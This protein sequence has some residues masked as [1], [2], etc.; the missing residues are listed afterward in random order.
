MVHP[1]LADRRV[2]N[3]GT[4]WCTRLPGCALAMLALAGGGPA[5]TRSS[6]GP[7]GA[8][9]P[10]SQIKAA[11]GGQSSVV[12]IIGVVTYAFANGGRVIVEDATAGILVDLAETAAP[13]RTGTVLRIEGHVV[14]ARE[15]VIAATS[16]REHEA[17]PVPR[18]TSR[19]I[20]DVAATQHR[21]RQTTLEGV[22]R[23]WRS[24]QDGHT[25][26]VIA[27]GR[28]Q[29]TARVSQHAREGADRYVDA[30][31][32]VTGAGRAVRDVRGARIGIDLLVPSLDQIE[33]IEPAPEAFTQPL[34]E[35][36]ALGHAPGD[37]PQRRVHVRGRLTR[38]RD[39]TWR[40][41]DHTG[42]VA[43][44]RVLLDVSAHDTLVSVLGV[45]RD[46]P[47]QRAR[48]ALSEV[49]IGPVATS[50]HPA[51]TVEPPARHTPITAAAELRALPRAVAGQRLPVSLRG[52]VTYFDP[53]WLPLFVQD[54]SGG[55]YVHL[56]NTSNSEH[57]EPGDVVEVTGRSDS[58]GFAPMVAEPVIRRT[59]R[60]ALP[61]P[62]TVPVAA[63][64]GGRYDSAWVETEAII[65]AAERAESDAHLTLHAIDGANRFR[66]TMPATADTPVPTHLVDARVR[67][68]GV[69]GAVYNGRQQMLGVQLLVPNLSLI[70]VLS[71]P[72][73]A[74][75]S[76]PVQ[77]VSAP[78]Q[79]SPDDEA[80]HRL[81]V[82]G[83]VTYVGAGRML[84]VQDAVTGLLVETT[85]QPPD[86]QPGDHV[87]VAGFP[88]TGGATASLQHAVVRRLAT[89][90]PPDPELVTADEVMTGNHDGR[91]V[92][93]DA[94]LL[95]TLPR[96]AQE[97]LLTLQ[98]GDHVF[99]AV[100]PVSRT[101]GPAD[102]M[103]R[104]G[105]LVS[106]T[107]VCA[108]QAD[109]TTPG[110]GGSARVESFRLL[111]RSPADVAVLV[112]APWWNMTHVITLAGVLGLV[113]LSGIGWVVSL[114]RTVLVQ[115][116]LIQRQLD[117]EARLTLEAQNANRAKSEFLANMSH[118]IRT[119]MNAVIGMTGLLLDTPLSAEQR[120]FVSTV[121]S[122]GD[123]LLHLI[124][125]ILDFS[126]I[127]S[128]HL[129]VESRPFVLRH[130]V[131]DT[132]DL[133]AAQ[134]TDKGLD[135]AAVIDADCPN[136]LVGDA[137]RLRQ[138]LVNLVGNAVKF[139][140]H[141]AVVLRVSSTRMSDADEAPYAWTFVVSDTGPGIP[142]DRQHRLFQAFSQVDASTTRRFGGTGLGLAI[143]R[144]LAQAMGG[145]LDV[146]SDAGRGAS[147]TC[148][149]TAPGRHVEVDVP[150][151][152]SLR[153]KRFLVV[154]G[155]AATRE[156]V[157]ALARQWG[158]DVV[159]AASAEE[160]HRRLDVEGPFDIAGVD[161]QLAHADPLRL[162]ESL[163]E[164]NRGERLRVLSM[165]GVGHAG[166]GTRHGFDGWLTRPLKASSLLNALMSAVGDSHAV[167]RPD[168]GPSRQPTHGRRARCVCSSPKTT[169]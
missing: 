53:A 96:S 164:R 12:A 77:S 66:V 107:G 97:H 50:R 72:R 139:T 88:T 16:H 15:P 34:T 48:L 114:R 22:V 159:D 99:T 19:A 49:T 92:R 127:E 23:S 70:T 132:L 126:K 136:Q 27:H 56:P 94:Y 111:L 40:L 134:A 65:V 131:E 119:P 57:F 85:D 137:T 73:A 160:A 39:G 89:G 121:R 24:E 84:Y 17:R 33:V 112:A 154:D 2:S 87:D 161:L 71:A 1:P 91:L 151:L 46:H 54:S 115:T 7:N 150:G 78:L 76:L 30:V 108:I 58:G 18:R 59:G 52:V 4:R 109:A 90:R 28:T 62:I 43:I 105:S 135:L 26:L 25:S 37:A 3:R 146:Q 162:V 38:E 95:D 104:P 68:R 79:F 147:F 116:A 21:Y 6:A 155:H 167:G 47:Y 130:C 36:A 120:E 98:A 122:S 148:T 102:A 101:G 143:S 117:Q 51:D 69:A 11:P 168:T 100:V 140:T 141:G 14:G 64:F 20:D 80:G 5:C 44:P 32:R 153:G 128:G 157:V 163:R 74:P 123:A 124:N 41:D 75:F 8:V 149:V 29:F 152:P 83:M 103:W 158:L 93:L 144:R 13:V 145:D 9:V 35:I 81:R 138:I 169:R 55:V 86:L 165:S 106:L 142:K 61:V 125:D 129:E 60:A 166:R 31:V 156:V 82:Q 67:L 113:V 133:F 118:E 45:V 10:I 110:A 63:L 42:A